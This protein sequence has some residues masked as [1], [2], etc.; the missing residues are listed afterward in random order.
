MFAVERAVAF[1]VQSYGL[2]AC[3]AV[4]SAQRRL[5][6]FFF[7]CLSMVYRL[8]KKANTRSGTGFSTNSDKRHAAEGLHL[9]PH[10]LLSHFLLT[11][12][13]A[14][15]YLGKLNTTTARL[16]ICVA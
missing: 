15:A 3:W 14:V 10:D 2:E 16:L 9:L 11:Y 6:V 4:E 7:F 1:A 8:P 5:S 13:N 12:R